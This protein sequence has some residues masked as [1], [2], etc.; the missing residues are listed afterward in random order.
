MARGAK[1]IYVAG[2]KKD[3]MRLELARKLGADEV[4]NVT[5]T[6]V[7]QFI[8]EKT[9]NEGVPLVI[10]AAGNKHSLSLAISTVSPRGQITK[11]G[12]GPE[13]IDLTLDPLL[14]KAAR[15]QGTFSHNWST[16]DA[17]ISMISYGTI[18]METMI[19]HRITIDQWLKTFEAMEKCEVIKAVVLFNQ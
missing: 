1:P 16:W 4:I 12:W 18:K 14:S 8:N 13:P 6:D 7:R 11:I 17:V 5:D 10:D 19:S 2:A 3:R 9:H 15:L